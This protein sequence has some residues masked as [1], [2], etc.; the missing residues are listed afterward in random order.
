M[1]AII[2]TIGCG[3]GALFI[4]CMAGCAH[5][6][7]ESAGQYT[8]LSALSATSDGPEQRVYSTAITA[9]DGS[10]ASITQGSNK[11]GADDELAERVRKRVLSD[12]TLVPYPSK[13]TVS[14]DP[15][16]KG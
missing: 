8:D 12:P 3:F 9:P 6:Q 10:K 7:S 5:R 13:V 16:E 15:S 1:K 14:S 11:S 2:A 4:L